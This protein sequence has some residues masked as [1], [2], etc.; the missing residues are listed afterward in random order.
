ME[1]QLSFMLYLLVQNLA[2][3]CVERNLIT[4]IQPE[5]T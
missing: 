1:G 2:V 5:G 4:G 3:V